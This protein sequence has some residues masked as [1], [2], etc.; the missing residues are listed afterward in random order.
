MKAIYLIRG[1]YPKYVKN[2]YNLAPKTNNLIKTWA[3]ELNIFPKK[4]YRWTTGII[5]KIVLKDTNYPGNAYQNHN[6]ASL[7]T[8]ENGS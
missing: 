8:C 4:P 6:E 1:Y 3:E 5:H 7:H 2:S